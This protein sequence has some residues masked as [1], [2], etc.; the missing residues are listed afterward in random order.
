V[1]LSALTVASAGR[2]VFEAGAF[3]LDGE[4]ERELA[5]YLHRVAMDPTLRGYPQDVPAVPIVVDFSGVADSPEETVVCGSD[6]SYEYIRE[7]A[8]YRT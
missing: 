4:V 8:D 1:D 6:L 3:R 7:N 5:D 2:R